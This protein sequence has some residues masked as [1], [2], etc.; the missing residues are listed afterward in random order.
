MIALSQPAL[1]PT[2]DGSRGPARRRPQTA[3]PRPS[4]PA[5]STSTDRPEDTQRLQSLGSTA[6]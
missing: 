4:S 5:T 6:G 3:E 1:G 2:I